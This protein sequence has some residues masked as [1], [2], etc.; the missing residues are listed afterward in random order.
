MTQADRVLSTPPTNTSSNNIAESTAI[1]FVDVSR[2]GFLAQAAAVTA[3]GSALGLALPLPGS[4]AD[5]GQAPDP[6]LEAIEASKAANA[7]WL[8]ALDH[9]SELESELPLERR[10]SRVDA[11]EERIVKTDDPRWIEAEREVGRTSDAE[12]DASWAI[13]DVLPTTREGLVALI[14]YAV[15]HDPDG[16]TWPQEWHHGLLANLAEALQSIERGHEHG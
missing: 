13:L 10:R 1:D 3:G 12:T 16:Y 14:M 9:H 2:R 11:W 4:T 5:A 15:V 7:K 8:A 6:I